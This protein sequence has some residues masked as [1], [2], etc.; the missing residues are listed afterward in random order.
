MQADTISTSPHTSKNVRFALETPAT[1][2]TVS[3][4]KSGVDDPGESITDICSSL[5]ASQKR[6]EAISYLVDEDDDN[7][8]H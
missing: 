4:Q 7:H 3:L 8:K 5:C 1:A 6:K 2:T